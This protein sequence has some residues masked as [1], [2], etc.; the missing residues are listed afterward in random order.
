MNS[1]I[2]EETEIGTGFSLELEAS[3]IPN[4]IRTC[5]NNLCFDFSNF[6]RPNVLA[7]AEDGRAII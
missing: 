2:A 3:Q 1:F 4:E 6:S 7:E 5:T